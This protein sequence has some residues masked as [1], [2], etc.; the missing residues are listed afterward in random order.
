MRRATD[1]P[2]QP[3]REFFLKL[4]AIAVFLGL[5]MLGSRAFSQAPAP[6][7]SDAARLTW[8]CATQFTDG[9]AL[10]ASGVTYKVQRQ[11]DG[12]T[13]WADVGSGITACM[14]TLTAQPVGLHR[15]RVATVVG[16]VS[17]AWTGTV[18]KTFAKPAPKPPTNP[19]IAD[20]VRELKDAV[21]ALEVALASL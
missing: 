8:V 1:R 18:S 2:R 20:A 16:G 13:T 3:V 11:K 21:E 12:E 7:A 4:F 14:T 17:S 19:T 15:F 5:G 6:V 9:T 10:P